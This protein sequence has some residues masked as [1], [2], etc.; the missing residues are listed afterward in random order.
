MNLKVNKNVCVLNS[1]FSKVKAHKKKSDFHKWFHLGRVPCKWFH[2]WKFN[3]NILIFTSDFTWDV[4]PARDRP[5]EKWVWG[6]SEIPW[7]FEK[8]SFEFSLVKMRTSHT[9]FYMERNLF[10]TCARGHVP[11]DSQ[12]DSQVKPFFL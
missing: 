4:S 1:I 12:G 5:Y 8:F 3:G 9:N 11:R 10:F 6:T 7:D 2:K